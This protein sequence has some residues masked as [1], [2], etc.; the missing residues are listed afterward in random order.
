MMTF[1]RSSVVASLSSDFS[2][3]HSR[4]S[5]SVS[6]IRSVSWL[7]NSSGSTFFGCSA[8]RS[9]GISR[10]DT[11]KPHSMARAPFFSTF[12]NPAPN[13]SPVFGTSL[14]GMKHRVMFCIR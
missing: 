6:P 7:M 4:N 8:S 1:C 2:R 14:S 13:R 5:F 11:V 3:Y 12:L 9:F 10:T